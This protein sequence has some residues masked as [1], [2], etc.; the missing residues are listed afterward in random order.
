MTARPTL[1]SFAGRWSLDRVIE[2]AG[3]GRAGR[4]AGEARFAPDGPGALLY[5]ERGELRMEGLAPLVAERRYLWRQVHS[6]RIEVFFED[7]RPFHEIDLAQAMPSDT[8]LC[9]PDRYEM[10]YDLSAWPDWEWRTRVEGPRKA[11]CLTSRYA[12]LGPLD[13]TG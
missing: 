3:A 9:A 11:Y 4:L 12:Y 7:G 5:E 13:S 2:D 1:D 6:C 8:H 10:V